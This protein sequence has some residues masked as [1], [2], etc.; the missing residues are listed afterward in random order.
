MGKIAFALVAV[1]FS[2]F[3]AWYAVTIF[4]KDEGK[5]LITICSERRLSTDSRHHWS[6]WF[7]QLWVNL[8]GSVIESLPLRQILYLPYP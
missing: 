3:Y 1:G 2:L 4:G 8:G 6:W 5:K 7:H